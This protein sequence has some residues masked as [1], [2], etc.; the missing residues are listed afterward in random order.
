ML[1]TTFLHAGPAETA[2]SQQGT[3]MSVTRRQDTQRTDQP[4]PTYRCTGT[5]DNGANSS[6]CQPVTGKPIMYWEVTIRLTNQ[7][8]VIRPY[9]MESGVTGFLA[10]LL[11]G[12]T[13]NYTLPPGVSA[14]MMVQVA[15]FSNGT[16]TL[17]NGSG[18]NY[19]GE[20][21]SQTLVPDQKPEPVYA[22]P[23]ISARPTIMA[24]QQAEFPWK[25]VDD[26]NQR[27]KFTIRNQFV[28]GEL[29]FMPDRQQLGDFFSI[30]AKKRGDS[31]VG[32]ARLRATVP[33]DAGATKNCEWT[34]RIE[35]SS[36]TPD[37]IEGK[38]SD[39]KSQAGCQTVGTGP[40]WSSAAIWVR[41]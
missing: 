31:F 29:A 7:V 14:G 10:V 13:K 19:A 15:I 22:E 11:G 34:F 36:V 6:T 23:T 40:T 30:D 26:P 8:L 4:S 17:Q 27:W 33:S 5:S 16:V 18:Q 28:F 12:P 1:F 38:L 39:E 3:V 35:L 24:E 32:T 21:V 2:S 41:E 37:R 9:L 25:Q 20:I